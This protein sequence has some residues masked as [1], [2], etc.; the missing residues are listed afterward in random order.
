MPGNPQQK[1]GL[2]E[3]AARVL[4]NARQQP[5]VHLAVRLGV[6]VTHVGPDSLPDD[7]RV[8]AR[9]CRRRPRHGYFGSPSQRFRQEF[10]EQDAPAGLEQCLLE[11]ALQFPDA[12]WPGVAAQRVIASGA[13]WR[14]SHP[15]SRQNR[16][17]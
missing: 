5:P 10:R 11:D 13:T 8:D 9:L 4:Q 7:E 6:Q 17:R 14:T 1:S 16:R 2:L 3:I 12:S 15:N